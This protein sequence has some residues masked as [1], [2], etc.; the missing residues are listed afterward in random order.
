MN[1]YQNYSNSN[2]S[3][4]HQQGYNFI[5]GINQTNN[6]QNT[7]NN[8]NGQHNEIINNNVDLNNNHSDNTKNNKKNNITKIIIIIISVIAIFGLISF[9]G[10]FLS[11]N[12]INSVWDSTKI[13]SFTADAK[14]YIGGA[15]YLINIDNVEYLLGG[16][17]KYAPSCSDFGSRESIITLNEIVSNTDNDNTISPF[18][19]NYDL[20]SSFVKVV[21][22]LDKG[23]CEYSY[24]IYLTDGTY[25]IGTAI[26]PTLS[27][28]IDDSKVK[29]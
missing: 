3:I 9:V 21:S 24:Y 23:N 8:T 10:I 2:Q 19:G 17:T 12:A 14:L 16:T 6:Q 26:N 29:K 18:D 4:Y 11:F 1:N 27:E 15:R 22:N 13:S 5:N 25:S 7:H 28:E 20:N